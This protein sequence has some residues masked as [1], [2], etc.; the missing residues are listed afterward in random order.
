M[1]SNLA[2]DVALGLVFI[3]LLYSLFVTILQEMIARALGLRARV[4]SKALRRM[5]DEDRHREDLGYFGKFTFFTW[6]YEKGWSVVHYFRPFADAPILKKFY[7]SPSILYLGENTASSRPSYINPATF[8]QAI[9]HLLRSST[10]ERATDTATIAAALEE[11][12]LQLGS[13]TLTHIRNL[14]ADAGQ[15][16]PQFRVQ[17]ENWFNETMQRA[18]S[19]YRKHC[20]TWLLIIGFVVAGIFNVDT[21]AVAKI[22]LK[23][24]TVRQEMVQLASSRSYNYGPMIDTLQQHQLMYK[25]SAF[26]RNDTSLKAFVGDTSVIGVY[27]MLRNDAGDA[28][29]V[30]GI[31][32][33]FSA[34]HPYGLSHPYQSNGWMVLA[35]WAITAMAISLGAP[36]WFDLLG[37]VVKFRNTPADS[38]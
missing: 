10:T 21:I 3:Y 35:G 32:R 2:I 29:N 25:D 26:L 14:F 6:F 17:L 15:D 34:A 20:Q 30:L 28:R 1:F 13:H 8:S 7:E 31:H 9:I 27:A 36:F 23:D 19:W 24:K 38:K 11:N 18:S 33:D 5:L 22:L 16:I 37:K 12:G 4:L